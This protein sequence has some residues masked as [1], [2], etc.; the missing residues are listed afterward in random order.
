MPLVQSPMPIILERREI[1]TV[2]TMGVDPGF[3]TM[4]LAILE[5]KMGERPRVLC[6]S[7]ATTA[8]EKKRKG[9]KAGRVSVDDQRRITE[10]WMALDDTVKLVAR[11]FV[12][13]VE[14]Y[15]PFKGKGGGNAWKSAIGY[16]VA[17]AYARAQGWPCMAYL[18]DDLKRA[19]MAQRS[20]S[21]EEVEAALCLKI[22][23][24]R[25]ELDKIKM[26]QREHASDA[27]GHAYLALV[28]V[29]K[30]VSLEMVKV[31]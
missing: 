29:M 20:A 12:F 6:L 23:G 24:L 14:A 9:L 22:D 7:V 19:F 17:S 26:D 15:R 4:G 16:G 21:K 30:Q 13:A 10:L 2:R 8:K 25:E 5:Q 27:A 3:A 18:P 28:E 31:V 11:P 1:P